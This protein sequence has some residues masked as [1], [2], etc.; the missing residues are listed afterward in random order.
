[1]NEFPE[2]NQRAHC[3]G[4]GGV[5]VQQGSYERADG[6]TRKEANGCLQWTV[7]T[8]KKT[9]LMP[10]LKVVKGGGK[11]ETPKLPILAFFAR[12]W[13]TKLAFWYMMVHK[14]STRGEGRWFV[15]RKGAFIGT[16]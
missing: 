14:C 7:V 2:K 1:M 15:G 3:K 8:P 6:S 11:E 5:N 13:A 4:G 10:D 9:D 12:K 16:Y